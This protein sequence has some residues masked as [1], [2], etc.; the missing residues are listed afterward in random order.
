MRQLARR[1][2]RED[3]LDDIARAVNK[4]LDSVLARVP[5]R[6]K[7]LDFLHGAWLGHPLHPLLV[8]VPIGAWTTAVFMDALHPRGG[9][10]HAAE[11]AIAVGLAGA[12]AAA[13]AGWA[14]WTALND[15][16]R[17][18]GLVHGGLNGVVIASFGLSLICRLIS[19]GPGRF[20]SLLGLGGAGIAAYL[21]GDMVYRLQAGVAHVADE[22]PPGQEQMPVSEASFSEREMKRV[23][24]DGFPVL[25]AKVNGRL[26]SLADVCPHLGC[27]LA[28]G[29]LMADRVICKCHG[30]EFALADGSVLGG[31][32]VQPVQAFEVTEAD[33]AL[34]VTPKG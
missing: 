29:T 6:R 2:E 4:Q 8:S 14:D 21:G 22:E 12:L 17:R 3:S 16:Q 28:E 11:A 15:R 7:L 23:E 13:P 18:I 19:F 20:F 5:E 34:T 27:S 25:V 1:I 30:S 26:F 9:R 32:A 31:P 33:G 10:S 24:I